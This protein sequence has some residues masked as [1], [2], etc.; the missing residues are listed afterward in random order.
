MIINVDKDN[1]PLDLLGY[2]LSG[3]EAEAVYQL[4][5]DINRKERE[6]ERINESVSEP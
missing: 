4:I 3:K 1:K 6:R 5:G 2:I